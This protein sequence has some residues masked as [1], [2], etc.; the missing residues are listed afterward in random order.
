[1]H[2]LADFAGE[3][4]LLLLAALILFTFPPAS[5]QSILRTAAQESSE[6]KFVVRQEGGKTVIGGF[7]V[8]VLRAI[9]A[10]EPGLKFVGDQ[11]PLPLAR[12]Y[13]GPDDVIC[14]LLYTKER[15]L[16]YDYISTPLFSV[17]YLL[18]VRADDDVK[19]ND[20]DDIRK[21][22]NEGLILSMHN[23][24]ISDILRGMG[25]LLVDSSAV[26]SK[27]NLNKL[28]AN[29]GRFYCHRSPGIVTEI[30]KAGLEGKVKLLPKVMLKEQFYMLVSK[31]V[32]ADDARKLRAAI[33]QLDSLGVLVKLFEKYQD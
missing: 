16:K 9:E 32:A 20:W 22:G 29:R 25:G 15:A 21:L 1:M 23:F 2:R 10:I 4:L 28:L 31:T 13:G 27:S 12:I 11:T 26:S 7:C 14:G 3:R 19:V 33:A 6:P 8:D 24:A 30:R 18:V 17:N 5:A